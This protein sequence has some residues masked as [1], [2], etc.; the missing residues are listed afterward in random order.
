MGVTSALLEL[1]PTAVSLCLYGA[2][3]TGLA[4]GLRRERRRSSGPRPAQAKGAPRVSILKPLAGHDDELAENLGSFA[5]LDY[6]AYEILLGVARSDDP[7]VPAARAFLAEHAAH[8]RERGCDA[9]LIVT[10][11]SLALNP[12]VAQLVALERQA[13]GDLVIVSDSN[14]RVSPDYLWP[15]VA[16]LEDAEV[17]LVT[18]VFVG[19]GE[20]NLG[21]ALENLQI[22]AWSVPAIVATATLTSRPLTIGKSMAMRRRDLGLLGGFR[23]VADVLAEDH[24]LG[25]LFRER[26]LLLRTSSAAIENRYVR[27]SLR[28]TL[29]RHTRWARIRRVMLPSGFALE[30]LLSPMAVAVVVAAVHPSRLSLAVAASVIVVQTIAAYVTVRAVRG[31]PLAW[32]Y[33]PLEVVRAALSLACWVS[34]WR[35][36]RVGWR[37]GAYVLCPGS[38]IHPAP[39]RSLRRQPVRPRP[40]SAGARS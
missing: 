19:T 6:P 35:T 13:S 40:A 22:C 15:L 34:A 14:V 7:A 12:K 27:C 1:F 38:V 18:S 26:G 16:E 31:R 4:I 32:Y 5:R 10:D 25:R 24:V 21:A 3:L 37:G 9:R 8:L 23:C 17:G 11:P 28:Q 30:P 33:A 20:E 36:R 2:M 29:E 39:E